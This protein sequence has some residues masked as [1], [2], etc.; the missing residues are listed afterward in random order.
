MSINFRIYPYIVPVVLA[1]QPASAQLLR[2]YFVTP[3]FSSTKPEYDHWEYT[4]WDKFYTPHD[5]NGTLAQNR[6]YPDMAAP[7]GYATTEVGSDD[8]GPLGDV[9]RDPNDPSKFIYVGPF[10]GE[11][12]WAPQNFADAVT[13]GFTGALPTNPNPAQP[14]T[15][16]HTKNPTIRQHSS[17]AFIIGPGFTG[18]IYSFSSLVSYTLDDSI[19]YDA[20]S[21]VFQFQNQGRDVDMNSIFLRYTEAGEQVDLPATDMIIEREA[22]A[23]HA[24]FTFT[25]RSAL[26]WD[27]SG[28]GVRTY[29]IV[30]KA[31]G[32]SCSVQEVLLD[33][34]DAYVRDNGLPAK[35]LFTGAGGSNWDNPLSWEDV[36]G[37]QTAPEDHANLV[38]T[39][40]SSLDM[41]ATTR[42]V[43]MLQTE[44]PGDFTINGSNPIEL[45]TGLQSSDSETAQLI[46]LNVPVHMTAFNFFDVGSNVSVAINGTFSGETGF[47]KRGAGNLSLA[48]NNT[49][50]G[51]LFVSGGKL[52][53]SGNNV[54]GQP[55]GL[56]MTYIYLGELELESSGVLGKP[57]VKVAIGS[58]PYELPGE[59]RPS[60]LVI[61]GERDFNRP[62]EFTGGYNPKRLTFT[63]TGSGATCSAVATLH[64]GTELGIFG[65]EPPTGEFSLDTPL[66]TDLVTFTNTF[67]GGATLDN[68]PT[69]HA[70]HKTG[71][72]KVVFSTTA[73]AYKHQT[74]VEQGTL[75]VEAS[76]AISG[77]NSVAVSEDALL[78]AEGPIT[79]TASKLTVN[80]RLD[81]AGALQRSGAVVIGGSGTIAKSLTIDQGTALSPGDG[82]GSITLEGSQTWGAAGKLSVDVKDAEDGGENDFVNITGALA[83]TGTSANPFVIE[84]KSQALAGVAG[85][86]YNFNGYGNY[87]WTLCTASEGIT[88]FDAAAF[89]VNTTG[90]AN[91]LHGT[92]SVE[93]AEN[94]LILKY[95][96]NAVPTPSYATWAASLP[97]ELRGENQDADG[98]GISNLV[99]FATGT[100]GNL[101]SDG[102][103]RLTLKRVV[104]GEQVRSVLDFSLAEPFRP[105]V[106][107]QLV[108]S[109]DLKSGNWSPLVTKSGEDAWQGAAVIQEA[110]PS[111]G[112]KKYTVTAPDSINGEPVQFFRL[113]F[114]NEE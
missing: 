99:E 82:V 55:G 6:N 112:K 7:N 28:K 52:N 18:N 53:V 19:D 71:P 69:P 81:G 89:T 2:P 74:K 10:N 9:A 47:E 24:G 109:P 80:G 54:Y 65:I 29:Q 104:D 26:E 101:A 59:S 17:S 42:K 87:S 79:L 8:L 102:T 43:S 84:L 31:A 27:L 98:D 70:L 58:T 111:G 4:R 46:T 107:V 103:P 68:T 45:G 62:I 91:T 13:S 75:L 1:A 64:N 86:V 32:T 22:F 66:E 12:V 94:S 114:L 48:G 83:L 39:G 51:A 21:V 76:S 40:G 15:I 88:G 50:T 56:D 72:G 35:R 93:Q 78:T 23:S 110:E 16:F 3:D 63:E 41:G 25:T 34:A 96:S 60:S 108:S 61:K 20:G 38:L 49:F 77:G 44:L 67:T 90:F 36:A 100:N 113:R 11:Y 5:G 85:K 105:G 33:T 30:W 106:V 57:N 95:T 92:F 73:K 97:A 14:R 37:N